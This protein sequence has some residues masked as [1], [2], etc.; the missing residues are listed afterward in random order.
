[1]GAGEAFSVSMRSESSSPTSIR[2]KA[3]HANTS[4]PVVKLM[5]RYSKQN[6]G[7]TEVQMEHGIQVLRYG[8]V[9]SRVLLTWSELLFGID[10]GLFAFEEVGSVATDHL[11]AGDDSDLVMALVIGEE[12]Y[13]RALE[14][15]R[16]LS[17]MEPAQPVTSMRRTWTFLLLSWVFEHPDVYE[18]RLSIAELVYADMDYPESMSRFVRY[19]PDEERELGSDGRLLEEW[20]S[21]LD[22]EGRFFRERR[23]RMD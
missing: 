9:R 23:I 14:A 22:R 11:S 1:M 21:Y 7:R 18:D 5:A 15:I 8:Y 6:S 10:E 3:Q 13:E 17:G 19:M 20:A 4:S 2:S 12:R 16:S